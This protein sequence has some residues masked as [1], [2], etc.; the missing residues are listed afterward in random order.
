MTLHQTIFRAYDI[1]G[2]VGETLTHET[3]YLVGYAFADLLESKQHPVIVCRDGR[4]TS[5]TISKELM[6]GLMDGGAEVLDIGV[7]PTPMLYFAVHTM[8][9]VG[10]IMVTGSHNPPR[11]N[12]FKMMRGKRALFGDDI[13]AI[14]HKC[15]QLQGQDLKSQTKMPVKGYVENYVDNLLDSAA[16]ASREL[17]IAWDPGNGAT[18]E[19]IEELTAKLPGEHFV[20]NSEID[21]HFPAHHPDPSNEANMQ[22]LKEL[23]LREKCNL[24]FAFDGDGDRVGIIDDKGQI[25][26]GDQIL[27]LLSR[28][29]LKRKPGATIIADVKTSQAFFDDVK[30]CGGKPLMWK[31]GHSLIKAKMKEVGAALGGEMSGHI[32]FAEGYYGFDDGIYA[33]LRFIDMLYESEKPMSDM[34]ATLPQLMSTPEMHHECADDVKFQVV[35]NLKTKLKE[36]GQTFNDVDGIRYENGE[37]WWLLR[38]SN[39]QPAL[40]TRV[41]AKTKEGLLHLQDMLKGLMA[42]VMPPR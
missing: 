37:G 19:V 8:A 27:L 3:A 31:T 38:A 18:G 21:G 41:E 13:Q 35:E 30:A 4:L 23:V 32:F 42:A 39:T 15:V 20:I 10:G 29:M 16:A 6:R 25:L 1:R 22:Q 34:T 24:G 40:I 26:V 28:Q 36:Q 7:G 17:K 9:C 2:V 33:A 5:P 14:Y 12:G 11:H